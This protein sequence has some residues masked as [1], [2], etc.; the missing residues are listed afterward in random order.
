MRKVTFSNNPAILTTR[1]NGTLYSRSAMPF[2]PATMTNESGFSTDRRVAED[3]VIF[4]P[5]KRKRARLRLQAV[6]QPDGP[7]RVDEHRESQ[8][9]RDG[10]SLLLPRVG[11]YYVRR[12]GAQI[13]ADATASAAAHEKRR[14]RPGVEVAG[15]PNKINII[16]SLFIQQNQKT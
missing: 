5:R 2:K 13:S 6:V 4:A 12:R 15:R 1:N 14:Q 8:A 3:I 10:R 9:E 11:V 7:R 16:F